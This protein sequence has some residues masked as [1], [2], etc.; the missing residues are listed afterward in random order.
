[1][2]FQPLL[3]DRS[4]DEKHFPAL[5]CPSCSIGHLGTTPE[6]YVSG[7]ATYYT[8]MEFE[9]IPED[10]IR[11]AFAAI[12]RCGNP[13]CGEVVGISGNAQYEETEFEGHHALTAVLRV[14]SMYP[15]PPLLELSDEVP[16]PVKMLLTRSFELY[17]VDDNSCA[18]ALR[19]ACEYIL[20]HLKVARSG[21]SKKGK[22]VDFD[23]NG[24]IQIL[25][26]RRSQKP[27]ASIFAGLAPK[28][29]V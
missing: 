3:W 21:S 7:N 25:N 8:S 10:Y 24:R 19:S 16:R 15:A 29:S 6:H 17:W 5:P 23:L 28:C 9:D 4:F 12:C 2:P 26:R 13:S 27:N 1:M 14:R 20:D 11:T 22:P 18:N